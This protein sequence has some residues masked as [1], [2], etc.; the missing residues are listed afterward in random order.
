MNK[1]MYDSQARAWIRARI[2]SGNLDTP[3]NLIK[4]V[5][6]EGWSISQKRFVRVLNDEILRVK[7][8]KPGTPPPPT[9]PTVALTDKQFATLTADTKGHI[10]EH[11]RELAEAA[12]AEHMTPRETVLK[13]PATK[14]TITGKGQHR[15]FTRLASLMALGERVW[16][17]GPAGSGKT[18]AAEAIGKAMKMR[19]FM[20]S[21]V[22]D[23]YSL[24]GFRDANGVYQETEFYRWATCDK[25]ALLI[26]DEVDRFLPRAVLAMNAAL[27]NNV[28]VFP[29]GRVDIPET[30]QVV[31]TAN[32][33]GFGAGAGEYVGAM[34]Q[35]AAFVNRFSARLDWDYDVELERSINDQRGGDEA[36][37]VLALRIR[38]NL[39]TNGIRMV[40]GPRDT[41]ALARRVASG[42][43]WN[44]AVAVSALA[45]LDKK[46][47]ARAIEGANADAY[48]AALATVN[49]NKPKAPAK[50]ASKKVSKKV[51]RKTTK[52]AGA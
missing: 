22:S 28:A 17:G 36:A 5:R 24:L 12:A 9:G 41:V 52:K 13:I 46:Q 35:D 26:I 10:D 18:Y 21:P 14:T 44:D 37:F 15:M 23:E 50:K 40:W 49:A 39:R 31:A 29:T 45:S 42:M 47:Y 51:A 2:D 16:M 25:P 3:G 4:S 38:E 11:I 8:A 6:A 32:T 48:D 7:K 27:A 30:H 34:K 20:L 43:K 33:W 1:R 19:V